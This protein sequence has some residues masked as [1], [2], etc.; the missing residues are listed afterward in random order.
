MRDALKR[1]SVVIISDHHLDPIGR[2]PTSSARSGKRSLVEVRPSLNQSE[3]SPPDQRDND[4]KTRS[5]TDGQSGKAGRGGGTGG[6]ARAG[7]TF[8]M[9]LALHVHYVVVRGRRPIPAHAQRNRAVKLFETPFVE[10]TAR[11]VKV[12]RG[13]E[14]RVRRTV[15]E[16]VQRGAESAVVSTCMPGR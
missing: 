4:E 12:D 11:R 9:D 5:W 6:R 7:R 1:S 8:P 16:L 14:V 13:D 10:L 2:G 15:G 3:G